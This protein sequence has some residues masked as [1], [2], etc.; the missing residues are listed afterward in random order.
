MSTGVLLDAKGSHLGLAA[1][2]GTGRSALFID[3][4]VEKN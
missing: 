2:P 4:R 1:Y 3:V